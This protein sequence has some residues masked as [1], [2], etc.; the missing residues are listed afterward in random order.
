MRPAFSGWFLIYGI[1]HELTALNGYKTSLVL[2]EVAFHVDGI[3]TSHVT[4]RH[5]A[6]RMSSEEERQRSLG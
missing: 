2:A 6:L 3:L 4:T 5:E 1:I